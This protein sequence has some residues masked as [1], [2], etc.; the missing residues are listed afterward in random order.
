MTLTDIRKVTISCFF[1]TLQ[2]LTAQKCDT[3]IVILL[4]GRGF[5]IFI[6]AENQSIRFLMPSF[7]KCHR[8]DFT[9]NKKHQKCA[10]FAHAP[11]KLW[12]RQN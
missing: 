4:V 9:G 10:P 5:V 12:Q 1:T 11:K 6:H 2:Q 3:L 8:R 7:S